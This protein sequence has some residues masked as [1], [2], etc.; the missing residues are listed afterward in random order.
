ME[1]NILEKEIFT[2][3]NGLNVNARSRLCPLYRQPPNDM[4]QSFPAPM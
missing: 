4:G 2:Q 3:K 1:I